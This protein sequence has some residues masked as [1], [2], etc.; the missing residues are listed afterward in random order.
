VVR[1]FAQIS[2]YH[3]SLNL[4]KQLNFLTDHLQLALLQ[5]ALLKLLHRLILPLL[6]LKVL[7]EKVSPLLVNLLNLI[8]QQMDE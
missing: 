3:P 4:L 8:P 1:H 6:I 5:L 7:L 2:Q